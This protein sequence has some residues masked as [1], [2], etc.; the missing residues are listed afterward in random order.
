MSI[1]HTLPG[2]GNRQGLFGTGDGH[3]AQA[4]LL[5]QILPASGAA[6]AGEQSLLK[7]HQADMVEFQALGAVHGHHDHGVGLRVVLLNVRIEGDFLQEAMEAGFLRILHIAED[8]GLQFVDVLCPG[9]ALRIV[10]LLQHGQIP[11]PEQQLLVKVRQ[12]HGVKQLRAVLDQIPEPLQL[13]R[14]LFQRAVIGS[15]GYHGVEIHV[16]RICQLLR[17]F[18]GF[19]SNSPGRIVDDPAQA[20]IVCAVVDDAEVG[21]HILDLG[22]VKE[23]G[24]A[25]DPVRNAVALEGIFQRVGLGIGPVEDSYILI[26]PASGQLENPAGH[27]ACFIGLRGGFIDLNPVSGT[28]LRP[29]GLSLSAAVMGNHRV[30]RV[31]DG[32][33]GA[34]VLFQADDL[35]IPV[36][37]L[38]I[39]DVFNGRA[40]EFI[41]TL[42]VVAHHADIFIAAGQQGRQQVLQ[43]V[44]ILI[45]IDQN[46]AELSLVVPAHVL[47]VLQNPDGQ[48]DDI[49]KVQGIGLPQAL[50][51][52]SVGRG[53]FFHP[54]V[55]GGIRFPL[56]GVRVLLLVLGLADEIQKQPGRK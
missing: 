12:R 39:Q 42:I 14:R 21:Q 49:V 41:D 48:Q 46:V 8:A 6:G 11:G 53:G 31:Q 51:V 9:A 10:F 37:L 28:V 3:I 56:K 33:S 18:Q 15:A 25:D 27:K 34:V 1:Q 35:G 4:A 17:G 24:T 26:G 38:K 52:L 40:A 5:L 22:P 36:L 43:V 50:L 2:V 44:G 54:V 32:L 47:E 7:A 20:Q 45:L 23:P 16:L 30:G 55:A 19:Q 29:E 13:S